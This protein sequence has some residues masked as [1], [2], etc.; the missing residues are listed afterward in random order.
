LAVL[1]QEYHITLLDSASTQDYHSYI[2]LD[3]NDFTFIFKT[4]NDK[5]LV[6]LNDKLI[7]E[8]DSSFFY[9]NKL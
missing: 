4:T 1:N 5:I 3:K 9:I 6:Y 8:L 7:F 2:V